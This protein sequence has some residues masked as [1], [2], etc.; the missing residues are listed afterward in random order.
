MEL[1]VFKFITQNY[2]VF[3][4]LLQLG[5]IPFSVAFHYKIYLFYKDLN[6]PKMLAYSLTAEEF[7]V[8]ENTVQRA[9][10]EMEEIVAV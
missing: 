2:A 5:K 4:T 1:T 3:Q 6:Q 10:K 8:S 7:N 9:V